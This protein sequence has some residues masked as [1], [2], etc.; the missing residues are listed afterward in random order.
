MNSEAPQSAGAGNNSG[1]PRQQTRPFARLFESSRSALAFAAILFVAVWLRFYRLP[2]RGIF[3]H[4]EGHFLSYVQTIRDAWSWA[5]DEDPHLQNLDFSVLKELLQQRGGTFYAAGKHGHLLSLAAV[6][7]L[8]GNSD[9]GALAYSAI[10][11][12][13]TVVV[14]F[15]LGQR[16]FGEV[17]AL[18][19]MGTLGAMPLA[20]SF[21]RSALAQ[22]DSSFFFL[23]SL[24]LFLWGMAGGGGGQPAARRGLLLFCGG[25]AAGVAFTCHYNV[26]IPLCFVG[27]LITWWALRD[28]QTGEDRR[29]VRLLGVGLLG[30]VMPLILINIPYWLVALKVKSHYPNFHTYFEEMRFQ[31][32][33]KGRTESPLYL[34]EVRE[35][36]GGPLFFV[37][38]LV[39]EQGF[40]FAGILIAAAVGLPL[41]RRQ[42]YRHKAHLPLV[43]LFL[44][45]AIVLS[46]YRYRV[47]RSFVPLLPLGALIVGR[48]FDLVR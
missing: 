23:L 45:P 48:F 4:D 7:L 11:G 47:L 17:A 19:A 13:L 38:N 8:T 32:T 25:L 16:L 14:L 33:L 43:F 20:V 27:V 39:A 22:A 44:A 35:L 31:L 42:G 29:M 36:P 21:S 34:A 24:C 30:F 5:R 2:E 9:V 1:H 46:V 26:L 40:I 3:V 12:S 15:F 41:I 28:H 18:I 10:L 6:S 37:V